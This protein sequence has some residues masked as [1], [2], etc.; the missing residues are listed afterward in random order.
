M[1]KNILSI[2]FSFVSL[3]VFSNEQKLITVMDFKTSYVSKQEMTLYVDYISSEVAK[4]PGY[5]LV[6]RQQREEYLKEISFSNSGCVDESCELEVG[7]M[8][9]ANEMIL[10][11]LGSFGSFYVVNLKLIDV[12]TGKSIYSLSK[13]YIDMDE[14]IIEVENIVAELFNT[15]KKNS[16]ISK[17]DSETDNTLKIKVTRDIL[18]HKTYIWNDKIYEP[19][20]YGSN[21]EKLFNDIKRKG[22]YD[23]HL[24]NIGDD[25]ITS[26]NVAKGFFWAGIVGMGVGPTVSI[27]GLAGLAGS[28]NY[29]DKTV[30]TYT[31]YGGII[32]FGIGSF[33]SIIS[34]VI[35]DGMLPNE[36]IEYYNSNN[37][38]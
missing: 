28:A 23:E 11:S 10:G 4:Y 3:L 35:I 9:S 30:F 27:I 33:I 20:F 8:L 6:E 1:K 26:F 36:Y 2:L 12:E 21:H 38:F 13:R 25:F 18:N 24:L 22:D 37:P 15:N 32:I 7:R 14:V 29:K 19:N 5:T 34:A 31:S 16:S 17:I